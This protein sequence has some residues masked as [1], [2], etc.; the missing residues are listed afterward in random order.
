MRTPI[1]YLQ[2]YAQVLREGYYQN[3]DEKQQYLKIIQDESKR[4]TQLINDVF[5]LS[6][7]EEARIELNF[8][9][10]NI[11]EIAE[12]ALSKVQRE[13]QIKGLNTSLRVTNHLPLI[14]ADSVRMEQ[15]FINLLSNAIRYSNEGLIK[16]EIVFNH[17]YLK[18]DIADNGIGIMIQF[19]S[20]IFL[21]YTLDLVD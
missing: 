19:D 12:Q 2:G 20:I 17:K 14:K 1:S 8:D 11:S 21:L 6:K 9:Y 10:V 7:M 18:V 4:L 5:E 16:M 3:N 13:A 15:I